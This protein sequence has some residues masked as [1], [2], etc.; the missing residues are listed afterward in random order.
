M[1]V[2]VI[3]ASSF[4]GNEVIF[5]ILFLVDPILIMGGIIQSLKSHYCRRVR[6]DMPFCPLYGGGPPGEG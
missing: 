5:S 1:W 6:T 4:R 2:I 3:M